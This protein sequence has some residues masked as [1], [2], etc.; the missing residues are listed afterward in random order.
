MTRHYYTEEEKAFVAANYA[1]M[2][3]AEIAEALGLPEMSVKLFI[4]RNKDIRKGRP[5][6]AFQKGGVPWNAGIK[7]WVRKAGPSDFKPKQIPHNATNYHDGMVVTK[8]HKDGS[9]YRYR[10]LHRGKWVASHRYN[11]EQ[12]N[13]PI[14]KGHCLK[15]CTSDT[16]NDEA[17]N[18]QLVTISE[19]AASTGIWESTVLQPA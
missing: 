4:Q 18:W 6:S 17:S 8:K 1:T 14:P 13:G 10:R 5:K 15:C 9:Q 3:R 12:M 19:L 16:L 11:W 2:S 7:G